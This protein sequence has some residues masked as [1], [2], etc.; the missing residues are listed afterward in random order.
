MTGADIFFGDIVPIRSGAAPLSVIGACFL[1]SSSSQQVC[2]FL[3]RENGVM[4]PKNT[5]E[6]T[7]LD[8]FDRKWA[9][10][11]FG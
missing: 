2:A 5:S 8:L 4:Q 11:S 6:E 3:R 1:G 10:S 9:K 7:L